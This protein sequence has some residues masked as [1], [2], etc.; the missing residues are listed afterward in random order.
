MR[1][2][3]LPHHLLGQGVQTVQNNIDST[4]SMYPAIMYSHTLCAGDLLSVSPTMMDECFFLSQY[5]STV[6][7]AVGQVYGT[8]IHR[9]DGEMVVTIATSMKSRLC[10]VHDIVV[11]L[12]TTAQGYCR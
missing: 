3:R 12:Y 11:L 9:D 4:V 7:Q 1:A 2:A 10:A 6:Q 5:N 8:E